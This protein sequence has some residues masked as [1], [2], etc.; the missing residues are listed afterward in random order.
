MARNFPIKSKGL[1]E[2]AARARS[3]AVKPVPMVSTQAPGTESEGA[4]T[5]GGES[6]GPGGEGQVVIVP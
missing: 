1:T 4:G 2:Q 3:K 6:V 5:V